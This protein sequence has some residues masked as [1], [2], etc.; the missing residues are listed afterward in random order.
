MRK[1]TL[2]VTAITTMAF[3]QI[4]VLSS[5]SDDKPKESQET[6]VEI[7]VDSASE[8]SDL[9]IGLHQYLNHGSASGGNVTINYY[10]NDKVADLPATITV[11]NESYLF[12][13]QNGERFGA[14]YF[15]VDAKGG[16]EKWKIIP[17][18]HE[19]AERSYKIGMFSLNMAFWGGGTMALIGH[20]KLA[21]GKRYLESAEER[22]KYYEDRI[23]TGSSYDLSSDLNDLEEQKKKKEEAE[24][25]ISASRGL[26]IAGYSTVAASMS[27]AI[28]SFRKCK[29]NRMRAEQVESREAAPME[30]LEMQGVAQ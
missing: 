21:K 25:D 29:R 16:Y 12:N 28:P 6:I 5:G 27:V 10:S 22:I 18:D 14:T 15:E 1:A 2:I 24:E 20:T 13:T 9:D 26:L 23:A 30:M 17:G 3:S 4:E 19:V 11:P 7:V 8:D